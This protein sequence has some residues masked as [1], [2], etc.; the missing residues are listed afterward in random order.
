MLA[1]R[2]PVQVSVGALK[3]NIPQPASFRLALF[4]FIADALPVWRDRPD[5]PKEMAET[6]LTS[7]LCAHLNSVARHAQ[8]WDILQFRVEEAD[9][10]K[11]G[12]KLDL[13][14]APSGTS[15]TIEGRRYLDFDSLMPIECKRLPTPK[16]T[17]RD[18]R[19]YVVCGNSSTGGI[20]RFK[21]GHHGAAH[22][23]GAMIG[24]VQEQTTPVWEGKVAEWITGLAGKEAGWTMGDL[25]TPR[26]HDATRRVA[27]Y[28]SRHTRN[29]LPDIE[30]HHVWIEM[31]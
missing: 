10:T 22:T 16:D 3:G 12:R 19:E 17:K 29:G 28:N 25:L 15:I 30:L 26:S 18:Q 6:A 14:A 21:A 8:G 20:Q 4:E 5:R 24:Y 31:N 11:K 9:E 23:V 1:N 13:V 7:R 27:V 2:P